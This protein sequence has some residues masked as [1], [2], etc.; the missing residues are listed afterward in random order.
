MLARTTE[1]ALANRV[2]AGFDREQT[3]DSIPMFRVSRELPDDLATKI[4]FRNAAQIYR[5]PEQPTPNG[6]LAN[7]K[8][9]S[10]AH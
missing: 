1:H 3:D 5:L 7:V 9:C 4:A 6:S 8:F 10:N 2:C